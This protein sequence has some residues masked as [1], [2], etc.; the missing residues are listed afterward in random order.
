MIDCFVTI[1]KIVRPISHHSPI[2][3][4]LEMYLQDQQP[5]CIWAIFLLTKNH[6]QS[7]TA[8]KAK[9]LISSP[10]DLQARVFITSTRIHIA[11][12]RLTQIIFI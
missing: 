6:Q 2:V 1:L 10:M 5:G 12:H 8:V 4:P 3:F 11:K 7:V 9:R